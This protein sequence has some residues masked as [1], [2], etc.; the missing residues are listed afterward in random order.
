[1]PHVTHGAVA[2]LLTA[3]L[4]GSVFA[5]D[6]PLPPEAEAELQRLQPLV[7]PQ[8]RADA[9][10]LMERYPNTRLAEIIARLLDEYAAY[11][12]LQDEER[13]AREANTALIREYWRVRYA[14]CPVPGPLPPSLRLVNETSEPILFQAKQHDTVWMGPYRLAAGAEQI[15]HRPTTL[16]RI[17]PAGIELHPLYPGNDYVFRATDAGP[18]GLV[19]LPQVPPPVPPAPPV[20]PFAN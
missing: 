1:M 3:A 10:E 6:E 13:A 14:Q 20:D 5:Q 4:A 17:T 2:C 18:P 19:Q 16:R 15:I 12:R 8:Q 11:D 7:L 9:R